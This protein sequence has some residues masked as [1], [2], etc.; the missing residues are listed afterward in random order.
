MFYGSFVGASG[1]LMDLRSLRSLSLSDLELHK[2]WEFS[3][4]FQELLWKAY[5]N[6]SLIYP[7]PVLLRK[8]DSKGGKE[9]FL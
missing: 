7:S 4:V 5:E 3:G 6:Y 1:F 9:P 8:P 2:L